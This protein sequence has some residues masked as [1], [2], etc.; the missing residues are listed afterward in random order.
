MDDLKTKVSNIE[1][2]VSKLEKK[3][4]LKFDLPSEL[5]MDWSSRHKQTSS[6]SSDLFESS[7]LEKDNSSN[8]LI[9][10][11]DFQKVFYISKGVANAH[12]IF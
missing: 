6:T 8:Q 2:W 1:S 12:M 10:D 9:R 5:D 3:W 11:D 4:C 7:K